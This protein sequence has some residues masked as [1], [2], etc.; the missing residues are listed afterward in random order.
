MSYSQ[1]TTQL[2]K[3]ILRTYTRRVD[4]RIFIAALAVSFLLPALF[5]LGSRSI[6][7][8]DVRSIERGVETLFKVRLEQL[9][10]TNFVSRPS[11]EQLRQER[12]K[13]LRSEIAQMAQA[14]SRSAE[15]EIAATA[16]PNQ[17][18]PSSLPLS[19]PS[20]GQLSG[21]PSGQ[22]PAPNSPQLP[23]VKGLAGANGQGNDLFEEDETARKLITADSGKRAVNDFE[24]QAGKNAIKDTVQK[25]RIPLTDRGGGSGRRLMENL[26]KP[27]LRVDPVVSRS[28]SMVLESGTAPPAPVL[29]VSEPPIELPPV[30]ELL[31]S[32]DLMRTSPRPPSLK[33]E[34]KELKKIRDRFVRLDDLVAVELSTYHHIGGDGYFMIR[35]RPK[36]ADER[37][38]VLPKDLVLVLDAS[39]SM[40]RRRIEVLKQGIREILNRLRPE[41]RFNVVG[42]KQSVKRFTST[43]TPVT[44]DNLE[45]AW[46][47]TRPL[48]ASGRTDIY[49]SLQPLVQLGTERARPLIILL[50]SDGRPTVGVL[51]S[52]NIINNLNRFL[53]PSTSI[54]CIGTGEELN[55]YLLDMLAFM[56]RGLVSY[57]RQRQELPAVMQSVYGYVED[58]VLLRLSANFSAVD[59]NEIYPKILP[60]LYLKGELRIWGR[61]KNEEKFTF[62]LVGE[63]F[64][65]RKEMVIP[66]AVPDRDTGTYEIARDWAFHKIYHL[67]GRMV[68]EGEKPEYLNEVRNLSRTYRVTTPY[69]EISANP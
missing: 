21:Q 27:V 62:R 53:G 48:E 65:E 42:F 3:P 59:E 40:G 2:R 50:F 35:I 66:L 44:Q 57:E 37:L 12:E 18:L 7:V 13:V 26:P 23:D 52:R 68:Q 43:L 38:R 24:E 31:P 41:D 34:E 15:P 33:D 29:N 39:A 36:S 69:S 28:I 46:Q 55:R 64:D 11:Q 17:N 19:G 32:P 30:S 14:P 25:N 6:Q 63:A 56:N 10:S 8:A 54:F 45:S 20:S 51:N 47:F 49:S 67:I 22:S 16:P 58:P 61:L 1:P 9:E 4:N 5:V 60:D